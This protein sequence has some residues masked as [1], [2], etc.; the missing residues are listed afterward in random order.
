M[1]F[2]LAAM[3]ALAMSF[4][5][6][7]VDLEG[8]EAAT[9]I[10]YADDS[11]ICST[12]VVHSDEDSTVLLSAHHCVDGPDTTVFSVRKT[13]RV[14]GEVV[15]YAVFNA[16]VLKE[17]KESDLAVLRLTDKN[18]R[19]PVTTIASVEEADKALFKGAEVLAVGYPGTYASGGMEDLV[20]GDGLFTGLRKSFVPSV[21]IDVYRTTAA[22]WYGKSGGGLYTNIDGDWKLVGVATQLDPETP[23]ETS[24]WIP[25][26]AI[27]KALL[28]AW[29]GTL[30]DLSAPGY[31]E[32]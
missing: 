14:D 11:P 18:V 27:H 3:L 30:P 32:R 25:I 19:F 2:I 31:T 8:I 21:K 26:T 4:P 6:A 10:L 15:S 17:D 13:E 28:G 12:Q 23:W 22:V 29:K 16:K 1:R 9:L 5:A 20:F 7:A 24:L